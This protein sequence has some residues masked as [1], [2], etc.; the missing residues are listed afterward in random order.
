MIGKSVLKPYK[1]MLTAIFITQKLDNQPNW[2]QYWTRN[3]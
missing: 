3:L 1:S 2:R